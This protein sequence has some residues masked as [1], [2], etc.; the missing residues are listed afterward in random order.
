MMADC[1]MCITGCST[2]VHRS[3]ATASTA[4]NCPQK[5]PQ[6]IIFRRAQAFRRSPYAAFAAHPVPRMHKDTDGLTGCRKSHAAGALLPA[7]NKTTCRHGTQKK[8][9]EY[10]VRL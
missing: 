3:P 2:V 7:G 9:T 6:R 5:A 4:H 1:A 8:R 10:S